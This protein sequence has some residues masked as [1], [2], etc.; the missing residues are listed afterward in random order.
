MLREHPRFEGAAIIFVSAVHVS[1]LD[2]LR[3]YQSGAVD[4][5][6][7]PVV[8]ELLEAKVK[9]FVEL[10][11]KTRELEELNDELETR[12]EERTAEL[13]AS[14]SRLRASRRLRLASEPRSSA[15]TISTA[16]DRILLAPSEDAAWHRCRRG[17]QPGR[18]PLIRPTA[19]GRGL[20]LLG[21]CS[22]SD[23]HEV[24]FR[25][26]EEG[27]AVRWLLDRG[28]IVRGNGEG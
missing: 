23:R 15:P 28:R 11:R 6:T 25:V 13:Q 5:I 3:G 24:E 8:P 16:H 9:V 2:H 27:G 7:V 20:C 10:Y 22:G 14:T 18:F 1:D 12:V 19:V 4:Y 17:P 21:E 26:L